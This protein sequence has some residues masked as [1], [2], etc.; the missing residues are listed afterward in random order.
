VI[1]GAARVA[2]VALVAACPGVPRPLE[3]PRV[4]VRAADVVEAALS[5]E[6]AVVNPNHEALV[7][8]AV[9]WQLEVD[10]APVARGR[11]DLHVDV[12][13][14]APAAVSLR[15][16]LPAPPGTGHL[17]LSGTLHLRDGKGFVAASFYGPVEP[18]SRASSAA[19]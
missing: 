3:E 2:L 15:A 19:R 7:A 10:D 9:D 17:A 5:A 13:A 14:L 8:V 4:E 12:A 16:T 6:L 11:E 1:R 18:A